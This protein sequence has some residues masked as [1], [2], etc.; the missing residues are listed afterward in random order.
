MTDLLDL[1]PD[2]LLS[3]TRAVRFRLDL[4][5]PQSWH[6][7]VVTDADKRKAVGDVYR[8]AFEVYKGLPIHAGAVQ[9]GDAARDA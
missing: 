9:T 3:T 4:E 7:V 6:F 5:R 8:R 2:Q 1:D